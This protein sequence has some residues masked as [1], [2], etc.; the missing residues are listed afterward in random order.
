MAVQSSTERASM[1]YQNREIS[2]LDFNAR[3]LAMAKRASVPLLD[4]LK[5][6][7]IAASNLDEFYMVRVANLINQAAGKA[8]VLDSGDGRRPQDVLEEVARRARAMSLEAATIVTEEILPALSRHGI[9]VAD[10]GALPEATRAEIT[11]FYLRE[12]HPCLTPIALDPAHP[13]PRLKNRTLNV[14]FRVEAKKQRMPGF[15]QPEGTLLALVGVPAVI[16][17]LQSFPLE[18]HRACFVP[19]ES[20]IARHA[21]ELF[22]GHRIIEAC[23][24][25][26]T[27][28]ADL[29]I[30]EDET[31]NLL[32]TIQD[33]LRRRD[34]R[35]AI[36]L[37]LGLA[38]SPELVE[39]VRDM[40]GIESAHLHQN[41][42]IIAPGDLMAV[43][44][45]TDVAEL[46]EEPFSPLPSPVLRYQRDLFSKI[47]EGDVLL[48]HPYES[49]GHVVDFVEA[50]ADDPE[51]VAIKMTLY[52]TSG[53]SPIVRALAR[54]AERGKQVTAVVEL[55]A[56]FDEA[57]NIAWARALEE[58]GVHVVYGL[59]GLKVHGKLLLVIRREGE[60]LRRYLH[61]STGNYN[62]TTARLYSD[63]SLLTAREDL[64]NDAML[65]FNVLT[66]YG[67]LPPMQRLI[68]SPFNLRQHIVERIAREIEHAKAGRHGRIIAKLNAL[69]DTG[70]IRALYRASQ[71]GVEIDLLVRGICCLRPQI[72]GISDNI[73][74][75]AVV[76]RFLEHARV[77][78]WG[79][80]GDDEV[81][82]TSA[83]WM[84]RNLNRRIEIA[85]PVLDPTLKRRLRDEILVTELSDNVSSWTIDPSGAYVPVTIPE[86]GQAVRMQQVFISLARERSVPQRTAVRRE[87]AARSGS[88]AVFPALRAAEAALRRR[89]P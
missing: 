28:A 82:L 39:Q 38:A 30:A 15:E 43:V 32:A 77:Y 71:A 5:F 13:F 87:L 35:E 80:A 55:K 69:V 1:L 78:Y 42:G 63:L 89:Q 58:N 19:L 44:Q 50:A 83:D 14:A 18:G 64:T 79:N 20:I 26:L 29:E 6:V 17:R 51:V 45:K 67:D 53:D 65:L 22:P 9:V 59:I 60:Q 16:P 75:R 3:V 10:P 2:W 66:G 46:K 73:R 57:A 48:H 85:F 24:F 68:V 7:A 4:R 84:P 27:R 86:G 37:E 81:W 49:F 40:L 8:Q 72:P 34:R 23:P 62:P 11:R 21:S 47:A 76:D 41:P 36:R 52:R 12:V 88:A 61:L 70:I 31:E 74:V 25:R 54:A 56:R 33:E